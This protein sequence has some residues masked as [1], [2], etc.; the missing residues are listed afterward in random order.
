MFKNEPE[1]EIPYFDKSHGWSVNTRHGMV[2]KLF[3]DDRN[4]NINLHKEALAITKKII[5]T[6][7]PPF[8]G[9]R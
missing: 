8:G 1:Y 6:G 4:M 7:L 2:W 3:P 5:E 9:W